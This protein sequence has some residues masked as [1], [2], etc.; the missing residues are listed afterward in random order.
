VRF[1]DFRGYGFIAPDAGGEDIF[2]HAND[3]ECD[4]Q[5]VI[6]G[7]KVSFEIEKGNRGSF[8]T[9]VR[10][11][12][13]KA[14]VGQPPTDS[15]APAN[16]EFYDVLPAEEFSHVITEM[17]LNVVPPITGEQVLRLRALLGQL[18][19]KYGWVEP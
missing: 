9:S 18:A 7:A 1:D 8:A 17:L 12:S 3:I 13:T 10:S 2:L 19:Q 4:R 6:R 16:D 5:L 11:V 15:S 14:E